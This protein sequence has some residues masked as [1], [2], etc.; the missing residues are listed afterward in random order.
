MFSPRDQVLWLGVA[1][2]LRD[3][4][5]GEALG[6]WLHGQ[7]QLGARNGFPGT[8]MRRR[9]RLFDQDFAVFLAGG[10]CCCSFWE[11]KKQV[12]VSWIFFVVLGFG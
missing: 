7:R 3:G 2:G 8:W 4:R 1:T 6:R 9:E 5:L 12:L 10:F 11:K